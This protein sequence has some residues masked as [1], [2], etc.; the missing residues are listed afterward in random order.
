MLALLF[1]LSVPALAYE[2]YSLADTFIGRDFLGWEWYNGSDPTHGT[3]NYVDQ[4]TAVNLNLSVASNTSF[5]MRADYRELVP[6]AES[7]RKSVRISSPLAY[8]DSVMVLD[9]WHMP[10]GCG[11]WPAW[12][13][14]SQAG[15]WPQGGEIDIIEGVNKNTQNLGSLHTTPNCNMTQTRNQRGQTVSTT[16]DASF[17][18]NQGCGVDFKPDSYGPG[19]NEGGGGWYAMQRSS[20]GIYM[21]FWARNDTTVPIEVSQ[22][23]STVNPDPRNWGTPDAAFPTDECDY[24]SHFNAHSII[25]DLTFCGDWAGS[26]SAWTDCGPSSCS[27]FVRNN[28]SN[29]TEA[30]WEIA[31]LR[32]YTQDPDV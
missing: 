19:F 6:P 1:F 3:V 12:W 27:D 10:T 30:Y 29:F 15:P 9:L 16:C 5:L 4:N 20:C 31:A 13:T 2:S 17:N 32:V 23:L 21:W 11:T 14:V 24:A 25:F 26:P 22:G 8:S 18:Y 7:G 28:P